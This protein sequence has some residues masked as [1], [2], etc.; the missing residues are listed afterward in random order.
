[1]RF[2]FWIRVEKICVGKKWQIWGLIMH[3]LWCSHAGESQAAETFFSI[4]QHWPSPSNR[5]TKGAIRLINQFNSSN[6]LTKDQL[7][8]PNQLNQLAPVQ[9]IIDPKSSL[10]PNMT[11]HDQLLPPLAIFKLSLIHYDIAHV[12]NLCMWQ[13]CKCLWFGWSEPPYGDNL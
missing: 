1:M 2:L 6:K 8:P 5:L 12:T 7:H 4:W 11:I 9:L 3:T 13:K 10:Q